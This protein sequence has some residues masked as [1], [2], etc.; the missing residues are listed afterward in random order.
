[1]IEKVEA[2]FNSK[3][4]EMLEALFS[5]E[6]IRIPLNASLSTPG[7]DGMSTLFYLKLW[8]ILGGCVIHAVLHILNHGDAVKKINHTHYFNPKKKKVC[9]SSK[10]FRTISLCN[11]LYNL[12][13]NALAYCLKHVLPYLINEGYSGFVPG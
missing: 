7:P 4:I 6:E 5:G 10:D 1:M 13:G 11:V 3:M 2:R 9:E 12:V 8:E